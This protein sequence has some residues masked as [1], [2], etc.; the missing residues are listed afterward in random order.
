MKCNAA[1]PVA[2]IAAAMVAAAPAAAQFST[3][4]PK[5]TPTATPT[6]N[7]YRTLHFGTP[8]LGGTP[9]GNIA[10]FNGWVAVKRDGR[11]AHA[12]ITFKNEGSL[13]AT[14]VSLEFLLM[15]HAGDQVAT[16]HL[17]RRGRFS[18]N[19]EIH[20]W[21][22]LQSWQSGSNRGYDEN[23]TGLNQSVA[24]LPLLSARMATYRILR[25]EY[26]NGT[27]WT[28]ASQ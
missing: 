26:A 16:L 25:V 17:D 21:K 20:G 22:D 12:C 6:P 13:T 15:N 14:R 4:S 18:P 2:I 3:A 1:W 28:P 9:P 24:A 19:I 8:T 10:V 27:D 23:C 5:P 7:P 11:G